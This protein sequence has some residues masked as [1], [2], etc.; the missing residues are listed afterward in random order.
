[1][2]V[3]PPARR[4]APPLVALAGLV[5]AGGAVGVLARAGIEQAFPA[6]PGG[7]PWATFWINV[8]GSL[9]LGALLEILVRSGPDHGW[10]R[11]VRLGCGTGVLGGFTTYSTFAVETLLLADD[12]AAAVGIAY[13]LVSVVVGVAAAAAGIT[14]AAAAHRGRAARRPADP[15]GGRS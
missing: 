12:G 8:A 3:T 13:A 14:L 10:R 7:W 1:M 2:A 11:A 6:A 5:A 15:A 4:A 9:A